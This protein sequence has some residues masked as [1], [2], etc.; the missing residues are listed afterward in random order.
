[1]PYP[2]LTPT[3]AALLAAKDTPTDAESAAE[4]AAAERQLRNWVYDFLNARFDGTTNKL[5][6]EALDTDSVPFGAIRGSEANGSSATQ[7]EILQGSV[8]EAD[9]RNEAVTTSK[10]KPAN[11]TMEC[12]ADDAVTTVK[13]L[14][15]NVSEDKIGDE[16][17]TTAKLGPTSVTAAKIATDAV[18]TAKIKD[19]AVTT[20]KIGANAVTGE[21]LPVGSSGQVLLHNGTTW[22]PTTLSG[23]IS[24]TGAGVGT[25][26]VTSSAL[27]FVRISEKVAAGTNGGA[28]TATSWAQKRGVATSWVIDEQT[29]ASVVA[30]GAAGAINIQSNGVFWLTATIPGY[31][32]GKHKVKVTYTSPAAVS[33][34]YIS[35]A[36]CAGP[37][38]VSSCRLQIALSVSGASAGTPGVLTI[39]HYTE[40]AKATNG[41]GIALGVTEVERYAMIEMV[42]LSS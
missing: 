42:R 17:V 40:L 31:S 7:R 21:K 33:T 20:A 27:A 3:L 41:L 8:S 10:I 18:E 12:L 24:L 34:D 16:Q 5:L 25:L 30:L 36:E 22:T 15:G 23:A 1:M 13:I 4:M 32:V 38:C 14:D 28:S 11:V 29:V 6:S 37:G 9:L 26:S 2:T 39:Y 35:S 19:G